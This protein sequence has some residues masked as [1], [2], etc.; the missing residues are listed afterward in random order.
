MLYLQQFNNLCSNIT[1]YIDMSVAYIEN[2][3]RQSR[4]TRAALP[5]LSESLREMEPFWK[6]Y[7]P[8]SSVILYSI[9]TFFL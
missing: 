9:R 6:H 4:P 7:P 5:R 8:R 1:E 2:E 3:T